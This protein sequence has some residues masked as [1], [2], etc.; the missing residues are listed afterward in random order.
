VSGDTK[1]VGDCMKRILLCMGILLLSTSCLTID[2]S[3][4]VSE[5]FSVKKKS[6]FLNLKTKTVTVDPNSYAASLKV[7]SDKNYVL[8]LK[9]GS[10]GEIDIPIK[11]EKDLEIPENGSF[12][13][14]HESIGQPFD[15]SGEI[16]TDVQLYNYTQGLQSCTWS[17]TEKRCDKVCVKETGKCE[18]VCHNEVTTFD[19]QQMVATHQRS[20][21]RDL[22]ME[23]MKADSTGVIAHFSGHDFESETIVDSKGT[24]R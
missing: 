10:I 13:I 16:A 15:L 3:L 5:A 12:H 2:G 22:S 21:T 9:G 24:C 23:F 4:Q 18:V 8:N 11:A 6:G 7:K 1:S 19:G 17:V 14:S 20:V